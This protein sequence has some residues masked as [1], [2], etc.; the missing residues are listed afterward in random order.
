LRK[1]NST[2]KLIFKNQTCL[3]A[4]NNLKKVSVMW[5]KEIL[6]IK[7]YCG[8]ENVTNRLC[9]LRLMHSEEDNIIFTKMYFFSVC[10]SHTAKKIRRSL[11]KGTFYGSPPVFSWC[12]TYQ[13]LQYIKSCSQKTKQNK[14][15]EMTWNV[16]TIFK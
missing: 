15:I 8:W 13:L 14:N 1:R 3:K 4:K 9:S 6:T 16:H 11:H 2:V 7:I 5:Q 10:I 12:I